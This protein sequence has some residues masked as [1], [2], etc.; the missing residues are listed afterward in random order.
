SQ[1][2]W[3]NGAVMAAALVGISCTYIGFGTLVDYFDW[4]TAFAITGTF[5]ALIALLWTWYARNRPEEHGAVNTAELQWIG[6]DAP[7]AEQL[8]EQPS[9]WRELLRNRN[10]ML[11]TL[12]YAAVG[13]FEYLF[14]FWSHYY[15]D[16]VLKVGKDE[17][18]LYSTILSL[19][20]AAGMLL[21]GWL[22]D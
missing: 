3:A 1:R 15:F 17:S 20:M 14:F 22:S 21:G 9:A 13:Y 6:A 19:S 7:G 11:L 18:R 10:L 12:S 8:A 16:D 4:P 5:T 2:A